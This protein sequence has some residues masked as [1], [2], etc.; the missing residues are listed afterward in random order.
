MTA[1]V[2]ALAAGLVG[3][4]I[5]LAVGYRRVASGKGRGASDADQLANAQVELRWA[6]QL[7]A[8]TETLDLDD[9]LEIGRASCRERV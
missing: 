3:A 9:L 2:I 7:S 1:L 6:R 5:I 4:A 8:L